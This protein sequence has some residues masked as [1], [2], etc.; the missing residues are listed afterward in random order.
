MASLSFTKIFILFLITLLFSISNADP[1]PPYKL[2][3]KVC[4]K[5]QDIDDCF[6]FLESDDKSKFAENITILTTIAVDQ[7]TK[8]AN[9]TRNIFRELKT[10]SPGVLKSLKDCIH[11]YSHV[12]SNLKIRM[13][14]EICSLIANDIQVAVDKVKHRQMIVDSNGAHGSFITTL[15]NVILDLCKLCELLA[16]LMCNLK[17][18]T[19]VMTL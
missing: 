18:K 13:F 12:I 10:G 11:S 6:Q 19:K 15:N 4:N 8:H 7:T 5:L 16:N 2:I 3:D 1:S 9:A 17:L 14:E